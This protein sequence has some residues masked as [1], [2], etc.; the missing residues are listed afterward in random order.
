[1]NRDKTLIR[2]MECVCG[3]REVDYGSPEDNFGII[4]QLWSVY[5]G[6]TFTA[7]DVAMMMALLKIARIRNGSG[8]EDSYVDLAGYAACAAEIATGRT[9]TIE[10]GTLNISDQTVFKAQPEKVTDQ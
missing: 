5:K 9:E 10:V 8:K 7:E 4:A 2:A 1:M 3:D 6:Q